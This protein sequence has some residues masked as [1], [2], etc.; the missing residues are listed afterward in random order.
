L[1]DGTVF[2]SSKERNQPAQFPVNGVI[3]GWQEA[4]QLMK[5]GSKYKIYVPSE[6]GYGE[7][8]DPRSKIKPNS[9]LIFEMELL[10]IGASSPSTQ[11][12]VKIK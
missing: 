3:R 7:H 2:D 12:Q 11:P 5:V 10:S 6:L 1:I 8:P 4:L 9:V